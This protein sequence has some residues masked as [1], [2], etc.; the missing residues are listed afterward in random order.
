MAYSK[1][2]EKGHLRTIN[3]GLKKLIKDHLVSNAIEKIDSEGWRLEELW[4]LEV[5][6]L[7]KANMNQIKKLYTYMC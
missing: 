4:S 2:V 5:D 3:E 6:D 1:Y 7:L